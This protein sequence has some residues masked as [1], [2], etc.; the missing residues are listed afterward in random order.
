LL[1]DVTRAVGGSLAQPVT[2]TISHRT[3][4]E[5]KGIRDMRHVLPDRSVTIHYVPTRDLIKVEKNLRNGDILSLIFANKTDIFSAHM[6]MVIEKEGTLYIRESSNSKM[7]TFDTPYRQWI[8]EKIPAT[9]Y[10]GLAF[11]RVR[12]EL[13]QPGRIIVPWEIPQLKTGR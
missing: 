5:N 8:E 10:L 12:P 3:F 6:L 2:R 9:R 11:M 7:T 4:F 1:D 13:D